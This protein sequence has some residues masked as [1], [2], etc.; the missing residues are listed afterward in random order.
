MFLLLPLSLLA[1]ASATGINYNDTLARTR[2]WPLAGAAFG[3][4]PAQC[5]N[6]LYNMD[7][8]FI[9]QYNVVCD[10]TNVDT[11]SAYLAILPT[12]RAILLAF[13]GT[14]THG[15]LTQEVNV[16]FYQPARP[17]VGGG[18]VNPFFFDA[19]LAL[20]QNTSLGAD[21]QRVTSENQGFA[22]WVTG[23]SLGAALAS[24][25]AGTIAAERLYPSNAILLVAFGQPRTGNQAYADAI[26]RLVPNTWRVVHRG[27]LVTQ[28]PPKG[29]KGYWHHGTEVWY[30]NDMSEGS[31]YKVCPKDDSNDCSDSLLWYNAEDHGTYFDVSLQSFSQN[32]CS[33]VTTN[34]V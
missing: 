28:L 1:V 19:H 26:D 30:N 34:Q 27:D 25:A 20:V 10:E 17:F 22:L 5:V 21:F 12:E 3:E 33:Q 31:P 15:E 8:E 23:H 18:L 11:C 16:T 24:V 2:F 13:R 29:F 7:A 32:G 6:S 14:N 4:N 9:G